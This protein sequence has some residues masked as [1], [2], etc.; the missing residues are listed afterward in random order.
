M[1]ER[2]FTTTKF[3]TNMF[4]ILEKYNIW[5]GLGWFSRKELKTNILWL[6]PVWLLP[7]FTLKNEFFGHLENYFFTWRTPGKHLEKWSVTWKFLR[8]KITWKT[9]GKIILTLYATKKMLTQNF[10]STRKKC[11]SANFLIYLPKSLIT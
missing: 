2:K 6:L 4:G 8:M 10:K 1:A 3:T 11:R 7:L 5:R 9:P